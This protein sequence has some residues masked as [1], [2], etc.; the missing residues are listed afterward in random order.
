MS[1]KL[2]T[3]RLLGLV[4]AVNSSIESAL[5]VNVGRSSADFRENVMSGTEDMNTKLAPILAGIFFSQSEMDS[6]KS[7]PEVYLSDKGLNPIQVYQIF[8]LDHS[9]GI[10]ARTGVSNC[11]PYSFTPI[12][13]GRLAP[14]V[15]ALK[16]EEKLSEQNIRLLEWFNRN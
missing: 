5:A 2:G 10:A 1:K 8:T 16:V 6:F 9:N 15:K 3:L 13:D 7:N 11:R 4:A 12:S 14:Q